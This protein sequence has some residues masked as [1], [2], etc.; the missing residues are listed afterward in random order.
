MCDTTLW[1]S[2]ATCLLCYLSLWLLC[3]LSLCLLYYLSPLAPLLPV[4]SATCSLPPSLLY[5]LSP[6][7]PL[8]PA[9]LPLLPPLLLAP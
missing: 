6:L 2:S 4:S 8:V 3:Y 9:P 5:Y 1:L 7:P